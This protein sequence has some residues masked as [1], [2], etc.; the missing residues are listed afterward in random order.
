M[1]QNITYNLLYRQLLLIVLSYCFG[2]KL[3]A[4]QTD[5]I[6]QTL[7]E[8]TVSDFKTSLFQASKKNIEIDSLIL[9]KYASGSLAELLSDQ[10][11]IHI[12]SYGNGNIA[13]TSMRGGNANHTALI[14]N[15]LNIQNPML[16]QN[17]LS[18]ISNLLFDK[19]SLEYGG[20]SALWGSGAL[21]GSIQLQN[22]TWFN[23][24]FQTKLQV[25]MGNFQTKKIGTV[26]SLSYPKLI[27]NTRVYYNDSKNN[28]RYMDTLDKEH[29]NKQVNHADYNTKGLMQELSFL[30][31]ANQK[32]NLRLW[33]NET[34]RNLPLFTSVIS[35]RSQLDQNLKANADW[36]YSKNN[37]NSIVRLG[38]LN[39]KITYTDSAIQLHSNN[40]LHTIIVEND[41]SYLLHRHRFN[42]GINYTYYRVYT[43]ENLNHTTLNKLA[44][45]AAY[46]VRLLKEKMKYHIS[47]RKEFSSNMHIPLT[48]NTGLLFDVSNRINLKINGS[49]S[50][51]QPTLNDLYWNPGGNINLKPEEAYDF[52]GSFEYHYSKKNY[53]IRF[54][55][56]YFNRYTTNWIIWLPSEKGYWSPNNLAKVYSRGTETSSEFK[57]KKQHFTFKINLTTSYV[58]STN[59]VIINTNDKSQGRQLIY[60]PRYTGNGSLQL[61]YKNISFLYSQ[62]YTGYRF[63]ATDNSSWLT[64]Y[65]IGNAK[66]SYRY[67]F[68]HFSSEFY[69][70][71]NNLFNKNYMVVKNMPMPM[72]NYEGGILLQ[73][74]KKNKT[75]NNL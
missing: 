16:G 47:V 12:K 35:Q 62:G 61:S 19:V 20:G 67:Q 74:H 18:L 41:N 54:E 7:S 57:L 53:L 22:K 68:N 21:G 45:Y 73:Y 17:D 26:V 32:I 50:F 36:N 15:G 38:F 28:Y 56:T 33:Y 69:F 23:Q 58:L 49:K 31:P 46:Q 8:V 65:S 43:T 6:K 13:T 51:R 29:P 60:T 37:L 44:F 34:K 48:G 40:Q 3:L 71:I 30:V 64:P 9:Q 27:V 75:P 70:N 5:S 2:H 42:L 14:W 66:L 25:S 39:D 59:E 55:V 4:Q 72:R 52:D 63:T 10:S 1:N 11:A 24:G